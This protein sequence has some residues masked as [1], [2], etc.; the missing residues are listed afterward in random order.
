M[1]YI[2][3]ICFIVGV[4]SLTLN[5]QAQRAFASFSNIL[6][7]LLFTTQGAY[8]MRAYVD[9]WME[10]V[11][12]VS[13]ETIF[14]DIPL[15]SVA[16]CRFYTPPFLTIGN[17]NRLSFFWEVSGCQEDNK[18][19]LGKFC[20]RSKNNNINQCCFLNKTSRSSNI[21]TRPSSRIPSSRYC[22]T[23]VAYPLTKMRR[24]YV[25]TLNSNLPPGDDYTYSLSTINGGGGRLYQSIPAISAKPFRVPTPFPSAAYVV[26][27]PNKKGKLGK[28]N[29]LHSFIIFGDT[30]SGAVTF[31]RLLQ[32]LRERDGTVPSPDLLIH[33]GDAV[34]DAAIKREWHSYFFSPLLR[35]PFATQIPLIMAQ[36]NHDIIQPSR[37]K[38]TFTIKNPKRFDNTY[39]SIS[40]GSAIRFVILN[41][42]VDDLKQDAFMLQEFGSDEFKAA[43]YRIV[44][45]HI[46]P[47][48]EFWDPKAWS[49]GEKDWGA[50]VKTKWV[51]L[52]ERH[53]VDVVISG[54]SHVYQRGRKNGIVYIVSGGGGASLED[55]EKNRVADYDFYKVTIGKHHLLRLKVIGKRENRNLVGKNK[56]GML[57]SGWISKNV[58]EVDSASNNLALEFE[59]LNN[60]GMPIDAFSI[61]TQK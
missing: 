56:K 49:N 19:A 51:P 40:I 44:L 58:D 41:S 18:G 4:F 38:G 16:Y 21:L 26:Q 3:I 6:Y 17:N 24:S 59:A 20:F 28:R 7:E 36:G 50:H 55:M 23:A 9:L 32:S 2:V 31:E 61:V 46:P 54:H 45:C 35:L 47:F 42:N 53:K 57:L 13:F 30:Q 25:L 8:M 27:D 33:L 60:K 1:V 22:N 15:I 37:L 48:I 29:L 43:S 39:F 14:Q 11:N 10:Y 34:Q 12:Y 52:F 5:A